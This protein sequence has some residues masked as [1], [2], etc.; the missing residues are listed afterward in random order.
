MAN[1][2][3]Q[4]STPMLLF[5]LIFKLTACKLA[6]SHFGSQ[7]LWSKSKL[8]LPT[9]RAIPERR[10]V[11]YRGKP[12]CTEGQG[13]LN[14]QSLLKRSVQYAVLSLSKSRKCHNTGGW[15]S[16]LFWVV[17]LAAP[18]NL[19]TS[20]ACYSKC[21]CSEEQAH[22]GFRSVIRAKSTVKPPNFTS[23][24]ISF[25]RAVIGNG[26]AENLTAKCLP[27]KPGFKLWIFGAVPV[28]P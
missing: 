23:V 22:L 16:F 26:P 14:W 20:C 3:T 17:C 1:T 21:A 4:H 11:C 13:Q 8:I 7:F 18:T 10:D 12:T 24:Q 25:L 6:L 2:A 19:P 5:F 15:I 27:L 28:Y 9:E